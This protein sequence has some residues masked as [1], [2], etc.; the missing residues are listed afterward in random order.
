MSMASAVL[1]V[2]VSCIATAGAASAGGP[3]HGDFTGRIEIGGRRHLYLRCKGSGT[4][5][6]ILE[7]GIHDS[8][9][10][11][12]TTDTE[13]PVPSR[14]T[15]FGGV[16]RFTRVCT[17]DRPG[18][19]RYT[20]PIALTTRS[21]P[22]YGTR[23]LAAMVTDLRTMLTRAGVRGPYVLV[24][25]SYG[26][27]ILRLF[28]QTYPADAAGLVLVD[29]FGTAIKPLFGGQWASYQV[30]LN[31]PGTALDSMPGFETVDADEAIAAVEQGRA[32][33]RIP[34]AVISKTEPFAASPT[35][36]EA[37]R[38]QLEKV[39]P[40]VQERLVD[41][42]PQAP[43]IFAT[44]SDHYV[45]IRDPDLVVSIIRLVF[46]R[47]RALEHRRRSP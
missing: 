27:L 19:I 4:P 3:A 44:G 5:V 7:S 25:H 37:L 35:V 24:A 23:T 20:N 9:D 12:S 16:A 33:P 22:V 41:L 38:T 26:G 31:Y 10:T 46:E 32:L 18:T 39:W 45:Q 14:P 36:P 47:A 2:T 42:G 30:I 11:W 17:Y 43:H 6:V 21:S 40:E 8:S 13:P 28:A 29:A 34:V 15:V 1:L